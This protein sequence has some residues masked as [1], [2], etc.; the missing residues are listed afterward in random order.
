M[1]AP[2]IQL[3]GAGGEYVVIPVVVNA[4]ERQCPGPGVDWLGKPFPTG[5]AKL[6]LFDSFVPPAGQEGF[7]I[8]R[9]GHAFYNALVSRRAP[10]SLPV[11]HMPHAY[12]AIAPPRDH[13]DQTGRRC[14]HRIYT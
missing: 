6:V 7:S 5:R 10:H 14:S 4:S 13:G 9:N 3:A 8:M 11:P 2:Y 1:V 12:T